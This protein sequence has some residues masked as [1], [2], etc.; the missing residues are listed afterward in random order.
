[1][2]R[3]SPSRCWPACPWATRR[4]TRPTTWHEWPLYSLFLCAHCGAYGAIMGRGL[5]VNCPR[6]PTRK[7]DEMLRRILDGKCP[8]YDGPP[9][10]V[11]MAMGVEATAD[12]VAKG[13]L[14]PH[15]SIQGRPPSRR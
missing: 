10:A 3:S 5:K 8:S 11:T 4:S 6:V 13:D 7:Q 9:A 1:M 12:V 14:A 2:T 15:V